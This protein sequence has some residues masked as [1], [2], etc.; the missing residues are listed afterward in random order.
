MY[1]LKFDDRGYIINNPL[2]REDT[3]LV[4]TNY[5]GPGEINPIWITIENLGYLFSIKVYEGYIYAVGFKHYPE[6]DNDSALLAKF[7]ITDG[8]LLW[9]KTWEGFHPW[10]WAFNLEVY[11]NFI[12][13]VGTTGPSGFIK[14]WTDS[15][16]CKYDLDGNRLWSKLINEA[17]F[18]HIYGIKEHDNYFYLCGDKG[19]DSWILKY[20]TNGNKI[21]GETYEIPGTRWSDLYELEI[22][23]GYIYAEG[24]TNSQDNTRQ[25]VLVAKVSLDGEL[26]WFREWGGKGA[27]LGTGI[28]VEDGYI[29][30][31]SY[32]NI[33][34]YDTEGNLQWDAGSGPQSTLLDIKLFNGSIYTT[35]T[36]SGLYPYD[37]YLDALLQKYDTNGE[38]IWYLTYGEKYCNDKGRCIETYNNS[39]YLCGVFYNKE[40]I[41]NY[42]VDLFSDNNKPDKPSKP[43][44]PT[45]G[46]PG[47]EYDYNTSTTDSDGNLLSYCFS[48]GEENVTLTEWMN[49]GEIASASYSWSERGKYN[50][51]VRVRD[52]CG[53]VS[54]WSEPLEVSIPRT[55]VTIGSN[56]FRFIDMFP[57]LQR[58]LKMMK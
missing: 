50:V 14:H 39:F 4:N 34:K 23:N 6:E 18:D 15:F 48:W 57:I 56:W 5:N 29:Y 8:E 31:C 35:G 46:I 58:I 16:I 55:R 43:S 30:V 41:L 3:N 26:I 9:I 21:W 32:D 52:E 38:L 1:G 45:N 27:Q 20:D 11:S 25:D 42:D 33:L 22:Y 51:R 54:D 17:K 2:D 44:G 36:I 7:D 13:V 24:Q 53:F 37:R 49:S 40:F 12:Y 10:T 47:M 28:D 19:S